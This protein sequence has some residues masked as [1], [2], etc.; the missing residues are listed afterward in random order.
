MLA[1]AAEGAQSQ[2]PT[3]AKPGATPTNLFP[4]QVCAKG[5]GFE[6]RRSQLEEAFTTY[7]ANL[8][9]RGQTVPDARRADLENQLLDRLIL[10][11]ILLGK[12]TDADKTKAKETGEKFIAEY[13]SRAPSEDLFNSQLKAL[14]MTAEKFRADV[15]ERAICEAVLDR[16]V[17]N[18]I[19]IS[20]EATKKFYDEN[21]GKFEQPE[22][23]RA[24]HIL[25]MTQDPKT[26]M[27]MTDD[28]KKEK[29]KQM[30]QILARARAGEDF[31]KL[32][33]EFSEDPG[34]KEHGGEYTFP[35]GQMVPQFEAAAFALKTNQI[36]DIVTTQ[37]GYHI[38]KLS[39]KIA[40]QKLPFAQAEKD[41]RD[42]LLAEDVQK[43]LPDY[44][45]KIKK[46]AKVEILD[47]PAKSG[48]AGPKK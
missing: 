14:G 1:A 20:N 46:E 4:D 15:M 40:A 18:Q 3:T 29:K 22:K 48:D 30:E 16:D 21:P 28:Q 36:S 23:V 25:L 45:A 44:F 11:R 32:A 43:Q 41:I 42:Y 31:A 10:T 8:A 9:A 33:K 13:R 34:S 7:E 47:A 37:S 12:A 27:E 24:S 26:G 17:K 19:K 6:I 38:I 5:S 39:E 2:T 35:R